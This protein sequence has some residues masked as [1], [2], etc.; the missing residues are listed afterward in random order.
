MWNVDGTETAETEESKS[1]ARIETLMC[2]VRRARGV[3]DAPKGQM[4]NRANANA[5]C[6]VGFQGFTRY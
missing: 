3:M 2:T 4:W 1:I 6:V 5:G